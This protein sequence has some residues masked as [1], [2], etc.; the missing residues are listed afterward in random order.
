MRLCLLITV[1]VGVTAGL[2]AKNFLPVDS[3]WADVIIGITAGLVVL[4][5]VRILLSKGKK[6]S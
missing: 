4:C 2:L 6:S 5:V 3:F 1:V